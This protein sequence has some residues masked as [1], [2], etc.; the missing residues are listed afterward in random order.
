M[1]TNK[2]ALV[3]A[4]LLNIMLIQFPIFVVEVSLVINSVSIIIA[5]MGLNFSRRIKNNENR[6]FNKLSFLMFYGA[7]IF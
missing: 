1:N 4:V 3:G 6:L 2:L 5:S 7:L